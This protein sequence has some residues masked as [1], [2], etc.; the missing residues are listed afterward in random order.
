MAALR[1]VG[2]CEGQRW[3]FDTVQEAQLIFSIPAE[4]Q[5][6]RPNSRKKGE[7]TNQQTAM[8]D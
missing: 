4:V 1:G 7:A 3:T 2:V 8:D 6:I 5:Q